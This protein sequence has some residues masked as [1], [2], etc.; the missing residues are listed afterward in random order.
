MP[1]IKR[2]FEKLTRAIIMKNY[3]PCVELK[4]NLCSESLG[5]FAHQIDNF[6]ANISYQI[7]FPVIADLTHQALSVFQIGNFNV[8][9]IDNGTSGGW[10]TR[11][12]PEFNRLRN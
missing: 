4:L 7:L 8:V 9:S 3:L 5:G 11:F 6:V 10:R 1:K 2:N 12:E